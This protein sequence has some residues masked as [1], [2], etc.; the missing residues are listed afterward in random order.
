MWDKSNRFRLIVLGR[1]EVICSLLIGSFSHCIAH[2]LV[3][4]THNPLREI[5]CE[6]RYL[7]QNKQ[8]CYFP[9]KNYRECD[10]SSQKP[11]ILVKKKLFKNTQSEFSICGLHEGALLKTGK[12]EYNNKNFLQPGATAVTLAC[13]LTSFLSSPPHA[14]SF[15]VRSNQ[16]CHDYYCYFESQPI[17]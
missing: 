1:S 16:S 13:S 9:E 5:F 14:L 12:R 8:T 11:Q 6:K 4:V 3:I 2:A 7:N 10:V 15:M 17:T